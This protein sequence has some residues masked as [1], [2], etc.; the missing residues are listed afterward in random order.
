VTLEQ[1][2]AEMLRDAQVIIGMIE[3]SHILTVSD[4]DKT[5]KEVAGLKTDHHAMAVFNIVMNNRASDAL[6]VDVKRRETRS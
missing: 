1:Q 2:V 6:F 4:L 5:V 3:N